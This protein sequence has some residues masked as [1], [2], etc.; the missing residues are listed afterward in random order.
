MTGKRSES[1]APSVLLQ[2]GR[3]RPMLQFP[4]AADHRSGPMP[5]LTAAYENGRVRR[6]EDEVERLQDGF[7]G[8]GVVA[9]GEFVG[10]EVVQGDVAVFDVIATAWDIRVSR[11]SRRRSEETHKGSFASSGASQITVRSASL[12]R[13]GKLASVGCEERYSPSSTTPKFGGGMSDRFEGLTRQ[14]ATRVPSEVVIARP[15]AIVSRSCPFVAVPRWLDD[16]VELVGPETDEVGEEEMEGIRGTVVG[17]S[18]SECSSPAMST[19][20]QA[21]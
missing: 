3:Q 9:G 17:V 14:T 12:S 4:Q 13:S 10:G 2:G 5:P 6:V 7:F 8:Q 16:V 19:Q 15:H 21:P 1:G 11:T 18:I 20:Q